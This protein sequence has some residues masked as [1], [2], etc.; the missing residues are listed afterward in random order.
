M[1]IVDSNSYQY[2]SIVFATI[3]LLP[4]TIHSYK[5]GCMKDINS[6]T[7]FMICC[8]SGLWAFYMYEKKLVVYWIAAAFLTINA[9]LLFIMKFILYLKRISDHYKSFDTDAP[10][11]V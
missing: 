7:L 4:Q 6:I 3:F 2:V 10:S 11:A 5:S 8:G 1:L 9:I